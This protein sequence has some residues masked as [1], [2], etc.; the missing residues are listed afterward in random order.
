MGFENCPWAGYLHNNEG[1]REGQHVHLVLSR[2][3]LDGKIVSDKNDRFRVMDV[4]RSLEHD[5]GLEAVQSKERS[6]PRL[7]PHGPEGRERGREF[8]M[9]RA[10]ID[11]AGANARTVRNFV[12]RAGGGRSPRALE[13]LAEWAPSGGKLSARGQSPDLEGI[14]PG[15]RLLDGPIDRAV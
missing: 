6:G 2:V 1:G 10:Q 8:I 3:T 15:A 13:D 4:M 9:L 12:E 11:A 14:G 5:L 7:Y